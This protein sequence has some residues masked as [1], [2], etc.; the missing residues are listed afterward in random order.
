[1][2]SCILWRTFSVAGQLLYIENYLQKKMF[3]KLVDFGLFA[4]V[5]L[6]LFPI[7]K[8]CCVMAL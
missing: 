5:F 7:H 6:V 4:N 3:T 2:H 8:Y 1:M